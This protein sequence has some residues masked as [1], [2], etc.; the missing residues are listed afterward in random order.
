[1]NNDDKLRITALPLEESE[2]E[3]T[4]QKPDP[5]WEWG[6][7]ISSDKYKKNLV[8]L[9]IDGKQIKVTYAADT[10]YLADGNS[11]IP[12]I[13]NIKYTIEYGTNILGEILFPLDTEEDKKR[14][15]SF[16]AGRKIE[17]NAVI[18]HNY[19]ELG[20]LK[21]LS[22]NKIEGAYAIASL[23]QNLEYLQLCLEHYP[24]KTVTFEK[25]EM[26]TEI[27]IIENNPEYIKRKNEAE[28]AKFKSAKVKL[29]KSSVGSSYEQDCLEAM[30]LSYVSITDEDRKKGMLKDLY[31]F[32]KGGENNKEK[33]RRAKVF[34]KVLEEN[35]IL[36][37]NEYLVALAG[38]DGLVSKP[39]RPVRD[40]VRD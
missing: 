14:F 33:N 2:R 11:E 12:Y 23:I 16:P 27:G 18:P 3:T 34:A 24:N 28:F 10:D 36:R 6:E 25:G 40:K 20:D 7:L 22:A 30:C 8:N 1:M 21:N 32:R 38:K 5:L 15:A 19:M 17:P 39:T 26:N 4:Y 37:E 9:L 31:E 35:P 13:N 29:A